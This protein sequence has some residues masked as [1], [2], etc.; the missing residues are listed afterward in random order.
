MS[1]AAVPSEQANTDGPTTIHERLAAA[2]AEVRPVA[3][4][5]QFGGGRPGG[6]SYRYRGIDGLLD[7]IH[8]PFARHGVFISPIVD[9]AEYETYPTADNKTMRMARLTMRFRFFGPAGD[10]VELGPVIGEASDAADKA[11]NKAMSQALKYVLMQA[12]SIP[13]EEPD[14]D[15]EHHERAT[16]SP[17]YPNEPPSRPDPANHEEQWPPSGGVPP[18]TPSSAPSPPVLNSRQQAV[19]T[20][21]DTLR[22]DE[23]DEFAQFKQWWSYHGLPTYDHAGKQYP[24]YHQLND[25]QCEQIEKRVDSTDEV[26]F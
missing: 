21:V 14:A 19:K 12:F 22:N 1:I 16:S 2:V 23:P 6:V 7:A 10:S 8:G 24:A 17:R 15:A 5:K 3:K 26:P 9:K 13:L 20:M 4:D 18:P 25:E 11:T